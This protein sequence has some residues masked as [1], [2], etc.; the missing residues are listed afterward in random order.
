MSHKAGH[1]NS[2]EAA[3][4][5]S[6]RRNQRL[7]RANPGDAHIVMRNNIPANAQGKNKKDLRTSDLSQSQ[8]N[9]VNQHDHA[10]VFDTSD[11]SYVV[12]PPTNDLA[13]SILAIEAERDNLGI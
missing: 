4:E 12:L 13:A 5:N 7:A 3:N 6:L 8:Q 10:A 9:S 2:A 11:N 1:Q